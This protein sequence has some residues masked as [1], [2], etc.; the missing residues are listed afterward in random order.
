MATNP[1]PSTNPPQDSSQS[2]SFKRWLRKAG[3][4]TGFAGTRDEQMAN[5]EEYKHN[6]CEMWKTELLNYSQCLVRLASHPLR[7]LPTV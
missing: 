5:L 2:P 6:T 3:L 1:G 7:I 4:V